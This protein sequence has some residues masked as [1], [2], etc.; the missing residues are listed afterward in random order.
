[1]GRSANKQ[2]ARPGLTPGR[3]ARDDWLGRRFMNHLLSLC[4]RDEAMS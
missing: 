1:M 2:I 4:H 3:R